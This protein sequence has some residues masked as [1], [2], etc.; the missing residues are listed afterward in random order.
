LT[1]IVLG[2][3]DRSDFYSDWVIEVA[4]DN[5]EIIR[6]VGG[7][8]VRPGRLARHEKAQA[9]IMDALKPLDIVLICTG[10][11]VNYNDPDY[12]FKGPGVTQ[13]ATEWLYEQG[14]RVMGIDAWGWDAPFSHTRVRWE[15]TH[16]PSIIWEGH[17]AGRDIPYCHMEKLCNLEQL[18][19]D[20]FMVACFPHKVKS[21]SGGWTR[22]VA[23]F[24]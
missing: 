24:E 10:R 7:L 9:L 1:E 15:E 17:Y 22:A 14:I 6:R 5:A 21:G 12:M 11:D 18:P 23:M 16:D 13:E 2:C 4:D 3:C 8:R 19:A 20:G